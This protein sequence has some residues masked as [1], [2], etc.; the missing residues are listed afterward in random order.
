MEEKQFTEGKQQG[1]IDPRTKNA[2]RADIG[3]YVAIWSAIHP[4]EVLLEINPDELMKASKLELSEIVGFCQE[5]MESWMKEH[6]KRQFDNVVDEQ[7]EDEEEE[8]FEDCPKDFKQETQVQKDLEQER[9]LKK[10]DASSITPSRSFS[11]SNPKV[12]KNTFNDSGIIDARIRAPAIP[13]YDGHPDTFQ[14]FFSL[15]RLTLNRSRAQDEEKI[16]FFIRSITDAALIWAERFLELHPHICWSEFLHSFQREFED[17][18]LYDDTI[19]RLEKLRQHST[20]RTYIHEFR[21]VSSKVDVSEKEAVRL[22]M[23]GLSN[24]IVSAIAYI[25]N[26]LPDLFEEALRAEVKASYLSL[27]HKRTAVSLA[28]LNPKEK[29][30]NNR[31]TNKD[32]YLREGRCFSCHKTGHIARECPELISAALASLNLS[33]EFVNAQEEPNKEGSAYTTGRATV[34]VDPR[35]FLP[36]SIKHPTNGT[37]ISATALLDTGASYSVFIRDDLIWKHVP[38]V[39]TSLSVACKSG[40]LNARRL[41]HPVQ[42]RING[43]KMWVRV[44]AVKDLLYPCILGIPWCKQVNASIHFQSG[45]TTVSMND[46]QDLKEQP[47]SVTVCATRSCL[48]TDS[49]NLAVIPPQLHDLQD[50]FKEDNS[51][52]LPPHREYD[53]KLELLPNQIPPKTKL[54]HVGPEQSKIINEYVHDLL[55][56]GFIEPSKADHGANVLL[57]RKK[58]GDLRP[59]IDFRQVNA[60]IKKDA[61]PLPLLSELIERVAGYQFYTSL[62]LKNAYHRLRMHPDSESLTTFRTGFGSYQFKVVPFGLSTAPAAFQRFLQTILLEFIPLG[63]AVYL[64][65]ILI[66]SNDFDSHISTVRKVVKRL[67][68]HDLFARVDKCHFFKKS[69]AYLGHEIS[70]NGICINKEK[71]LSLGSWPRPVKLRDLL[72][73]L[74]FCNFFREFIPSFAGLAEPL[75]Q[76]LRGKK[77]LLDWTPERTTAFRNLCSMFIRSPI[78]TAVKSDLPFV[79]FVDS[80]DYAVGAV[81]TQIE[82]GKFVPKAFISRLLKGHERNYSV[83]DKE[84]LGLVWACKQW[85]YHLWSARHKFTVFTDNRSVLSLH[86]HDIQNGRHQRWHD[87]LSTLNFRLRYIKGTSNILADFLSRPAIPKSSILSKTLSSATSIIPGNCISALDI[88]SQQ[89]Q[90]LMKLCHA[91]TLGGHKGIEKTMHLL[92]RLRKWKYQRDDVSKFISNCVTCQQAKSPRTKPCTLLQL[93]PIPSDIGSDFTVDLVSAFKFSLFPDCQVLVIVDRLTKYAR[94]IPFNS[95][96][97]TKQIIMAIEQHWLPLFPN[98]VSILSDRATTFTSD[99]WLQHW[100]NKRITPVLTTAWHPQCNGQSERVIQELVGFLRRFPN[101]CSKN[102]EQAIVLAERSYNLAKH[103]SIGMSPYEA[104]FGFF[105][106]VG[107]FPRKILCISKVQ[108]V[109]LLQH[110]LAAAQRTYKQQADTTRQSGPVYNLHDKVWLSTR[111]LYGPNGPNKLQNRYIGPLKITKVN[112]GQTYSVSL[113]KELRRIH[114]NFYVGLLRPVINSKFSSTQTNLHGDDVI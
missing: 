9:I 73:F 58:T 79:L 114:N 110:R 18:T 43:R 14:N 38:S 34:A 46:I 83:S 101:W 24:R 42:L 10:D 100:K 36:L 47:H 4:E 56:R 23:K 32:T 63:V 104:V 76:M 103:K 109:K 69:I 99:L 64:D 31:D 72:R 89:K 78:L 29:H 75:Y 52:K 74:G 84:L 85:K 50:F 41:L 53:L 16:T 1:S 19:R 22:F 67:L 68:D 44:I 3:R 105:P 26:N 33:H 98:A 94:F 87:F 25:P 95:A 30:K 86:K 13:I 11:E 107:L 51:N 80:S 6:E 92:Q 5:R 8:Q 91:S 102:P 12:V 2:L 66:F 70:Q 96:P 93:L 27:E 15:I 37:W 59:C 62:D 71:A 49:L 111:N 106:H 55:Q 65:D 82:H 88:T 60:C 90:N 20:V 40:K 35:V 108:R 81:L 7:E 28:A 77:P 17:R 113:P 61:Y 39:G 21:K 57:I 54:R 45:K 48:Q 97:N 112:K